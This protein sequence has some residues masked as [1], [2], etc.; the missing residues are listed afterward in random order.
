MGKE[1]D[2]KECIM[3]DIRRD[4]KIVKHKTCPFEWIA[5]PLFYPEVELEVEE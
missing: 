5:V 4:G 2:F 3:N 1:H